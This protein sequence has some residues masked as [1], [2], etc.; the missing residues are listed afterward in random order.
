MTEL[1][2][3]SM[4]QKLIVW[5][6]AVFLSVNSVHSSYWDSFMWLVSD[7]YVW[8]PFYISLVYVVFRNYSWKVILA[9]FVTVAL[10]I[11]FTDGVCSNLIRPLIGRMRPSNLDNPISGMV[12]IVDGHRGGRFGFPSAHS[13]NTWGLTFFV[14]YLFRRHWLTFFMIFWASLVC[15]SRMYLGVHYP[16]D[17]IVGMLLAAIGSSVLYYV[18]VKVSGHTVADDLKHPYLPVIVGSFTIFVFF[19]ASFFFSF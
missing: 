18:F 8:I 5:D 9:C 7:K 2:L 13:S 15:Y 12:H 10:I 14:F 17:L 3:T 1:L 19:I 16:G 6:T 11:L 4:L